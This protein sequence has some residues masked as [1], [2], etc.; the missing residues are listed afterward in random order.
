M[1]FAVTNAAGEFSKSGY[2]LAHLLPTGGG[3]T[4]E[5]ANGGQPPVPDL[6]ACDAREIRWACYAWPVAAGRT[7]RRAFATNQSGEIIQHDNNNGAGGFN[8]T[9]TTA[10]GIANPEIAYIPAAGTMNPIDLEGGFGIATNRF[11]S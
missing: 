6:A 1:Q 2:F 4:S 3:A 9:A 11:G 7:G 8:Y 10:I 5:A